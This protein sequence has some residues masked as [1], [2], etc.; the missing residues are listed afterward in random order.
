[1]TRSDFTMGFVGFEPS[2]AGRDAAESDTE[3][4][5]LKLLDAAYAHAD[6]QALSGEELEARRAGRRVASANNAI[7]A[8]PT[9]EADLLIDE[10]MDSHRIPTALGLELLGKTAC[11]HPAAYARLIADDG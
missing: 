10:L 5:F 3:R 7:E 2:K 8:L 9:K 4:H 6:F 11:L 1:M